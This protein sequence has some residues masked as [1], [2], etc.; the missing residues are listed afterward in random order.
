[1]CDAELHSLNDSAANTALCLLQSS[2]CYGGGGSV[3]L[4]VLPC[5]HLGKQVTGRSSSTCHLVAPATAPREKLT[6]MAFC[7]H[8]TV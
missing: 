4:H 7:V 8:S 2:S 5:V 6:V 3:S 1:M